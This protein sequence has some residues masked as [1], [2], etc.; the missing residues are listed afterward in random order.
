[1]QIANLYQRAYMCAG[2]VCESGRQATPFCDS[3]SETLGSLAT[4]NR[5]ARAQL[6]KALNYSHVGIHL[7]EILPHINK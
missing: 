1:M 3:R 2:P 5:R 6:N 4:Q 7:N